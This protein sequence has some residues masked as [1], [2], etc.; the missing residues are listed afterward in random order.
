MAAPGALVFFNAFKKYIADGT[1]DLDTDTIAVTLHTSTFTPNAATMAAGADL[2]NEVANG[3]GYTTGGQNLANKTVT[4]S[5][6]TMTFDA[7]DHTW[8][9]SG[10]SI[11]ARYEVFKKI[12]TANSVV[13]PLIGYRLL[14]SAPADVVIASG[15]SIVLVENAAGIFTLA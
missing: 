12:G 8:T 6:G 7:D 2:T 15:N 10:G 4:Q 9:A 14:D 11:T 3:N 5:G 1:I 13:N